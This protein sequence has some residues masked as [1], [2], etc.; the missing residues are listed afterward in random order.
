MVGK[1]TEEVG[2]LTEAGGMAVAMT[3]FCMAED[4]P[5]GESGV[6]RC[7]RQPGVPCSS[8]D[9]VEEQGRELHTEQHLKRARTHRQ[10]M[11]SG[12]E[13]EVQRAR[14]QGASRL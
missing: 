4:A 12:R 8:A 6:D 14:V 7:A 3:A 1:D 10:R 9:D 13:M 11:Q 5:R 2:A